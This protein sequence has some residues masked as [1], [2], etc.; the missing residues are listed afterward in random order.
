MGRIGTL[1]LAATLST[2][3]LAADGPAEHFDSCRGERILAAAPR[4]LPCPDKPNCVST[5]AVAAARKMAPIPVSGD[6]TSTREQLLAAIAAQSG[7]RI[8]IAHGGFVV[9]TFRSRLFG[10][11]DEA[12]FL[13]ETDE[14]RI[15]FRSGACSGYYDFG[16]N[17]S[18]IESIKAA[19]LK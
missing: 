12:Q 8:E 19:L 7:S 2:G 10:F 13:I 16:V 9:A 4:L 11:V 1:L 15:R 5:E 18:R 17:R 6:A 3:V 14:H